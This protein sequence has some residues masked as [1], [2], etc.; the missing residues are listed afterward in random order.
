MPLTLRFVIVFLLVSGSAQLLVK[1]LG[2]NMFTA[3]ILMWSVGIAALLAMKWA[4]QP[5]SALGWAWG[6]ARYHAIAFVLPLIYGGLAYTLS[7]AVG[8]AKF[9]DAENT[10]QLA[11]FAGFPDMPLLLA[12][13]ATFMLVAS[14]GLVNSMSTALGE[15]IGWRGLV[16]PLLT[17]QWGFL[18]ATLV[19]GLMWAAWHMPLVLFSDYNAGGAKLFEVLSFTLML[20]SISGPMAWLR[21]KSGSLWPAAMLH[22]TH[23]LFIQNFFDALSSRGESAITMIGEFG[24][25]LAGVSLLVSLPFWVSGARLSRPD[26]PPSS[27]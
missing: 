9:P 18:A 13:I 8:L 11:G 3:T 19:T 24:V 7:G 15:E 21:L 2:F 6:G 20:V 22:A 25:V 12:M 26:F 10:R 5:L 1:A 14:A 16:T 4:K 17:S 23:N 27:H